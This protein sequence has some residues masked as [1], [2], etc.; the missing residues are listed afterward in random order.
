MKKK[1]LFL[2]I[3]IAVVGLITVYS[4]KNPGG[5]KESKSLAAIPT[6]TEN[7]L[8]IAAPGR[9]EPISEEIKIGS[10]LSGKLKAVLVNEGDKVQRGQVIA[11]LINDDYQAQVDS[12]EA[13][14]NEREAELRRVI[15]GAR[16]QERREARSAVEEAEAVLKNSKV[17][18]ERRESLFKTGDIAREEVDRS[19]REY[20][21]ADARHQAAIHR[22][23][24]IEA[25]AREED[26][27]RAEASV[28]R[29]RAQLDEIR[30]R[31][32]KTYI[33]SP[34]TGLVLRKHLKDGETVSDSPDMPIVTLADTSTLRVRL[35]IDERDVGKIRLDQR[36]YVTADAYGDKKFWGRITRIGQILGRKNIR[37]DEP[38]ERI[39]TK[40]LETL[41][42]LDD[43]HELHLGLRV[44]AYI[45]VPSSSSGG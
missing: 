6:P 39:D 44:D 14:L 45:S 41:I 15:N 11:I 1:S 27:A 40:I 8:L 25:S 19:E 43:G 33:R 29:A 35:D 13:E 20:R 32:A 34:I 30:A 4:V 3:F 10:S 2:I 17:E 16:S 12:A 21:T 37:T 38:T 5:A 18:L 7:N 36:V 28:E 42:D 26:R 31:L 23:S 9:V 24:L 22:Q